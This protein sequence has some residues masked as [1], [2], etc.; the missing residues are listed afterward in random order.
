MSY[1]GQTYRVPCAKGGLT[2]NPNIDQIPPESMVL[3]RNINIFDNGRG[4]RGGTDKVNGTIGYGSSQLMGIFDFRLVDATDFVMV[5][6]AAGAIWKNSTTSLKTGLTAAKYFH[7]QVYA[8]TLYVCNGANIPQTWDGSAGSTSDMAAVP[9]DW[10][11]SNFPQQ[12]VVHGRKNSERGWASGCP[13]NPHTL[14]VTPNS[15][16]IGLDFSQGT[17]NTFYINTNDGYGIVGIAEFGDRLFAFGKNKTYV[18]DDSSTD[19]SKWGYDG[20]QWEGG[21]AH[22]RLIVKTPN[23]LLCMTD[24]GNIYSVRA[25]ESYGDYKQ[26]SITKPSWIDKWIRD[27]CDLGKINQFHAV[28]DPELR[29]A[30]FFVVRAGQ[31][32]VDTSLVY[33][34]DKGPEEGWVVHDNQTNASG[35]DAS[36]SA[37][38]RVD[39]ATHHTQYVYTG[40]YSGYVW[41]LEEANKNDDSVA[42][43]AGFKTARMP[44]DNPRI[45][46]KYSQG[47]LVT[48]AKGAYNVYINI[49]VDGIA[50]TQQSIDLSGVGGTYGTAVYGADTYGGDEMIDKPFDVG[51]RGKRIQYEIFN[52]NVDE[53]FF[54]SQILQDHKLLGN[55]PV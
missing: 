50:L 18:M 17:I 25:A 5:G 16:G 54:I 33:N 20:A 6:T 4:K 1:V 37:I 12:I 10:T 45:S 36:C 44:F 9:T 32:T 48:E 21:A 27:N 31:S 47:W 19:I 42:Y 24:D 3:A 15:A 28:Y 30:R 55:R 13:N 35:F 40:D 46:K 23:D 51:T 8:D 34:I 11:G 43:Y 38:V 49:W 7:F 26:A 39:P 14:Y 22:W 53:D 52:S 2:A 41:E 29:I